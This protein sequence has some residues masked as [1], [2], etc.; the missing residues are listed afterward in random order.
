MTGSDN[1]FDR[2]P[3]RRPL[4]DPANPQPRVMN[5]DKNRAYPAAV[6]E[7]KAEGTLRRRCRL[8]QCKYLSNTVQQDHQVPK[9]L[10]WLA[11]GY[12]TFW[13]AW[14]ILE[15]IEAVHMIRK[16]RIRWVAKGDALA[17]MRFINELFGLAICRYR[18][19]GESNLC[20]FQIS[21]RYPLLFVGAC[22]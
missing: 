15:G 20:A 11:R 19:N 5:V 14:P 13:T 1:Q 10:G 22:R 21:Q 18:L 9:K 16:G 3:V 17:Q 6:E 8:R 2:P 12:Q 7:L 4:L